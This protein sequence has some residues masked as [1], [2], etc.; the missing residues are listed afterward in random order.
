MRGSEMT[1]QTE[2]CKVRSRSVRQTL[3]YNKI[4]LGGWGG[5]EFGEW[6]SLHAAAQTAQTLNRPAR[7]WPDAEKESRIH[8]SIW[9]RWRHSKHRLT[10]Q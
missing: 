10:K 4:F 9:I 6:W 2:Q 3:M 8:E 7:G 5:G 1:M